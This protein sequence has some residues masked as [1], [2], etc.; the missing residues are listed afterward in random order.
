MDN[1]GFI[2]L[3]LNNHNSS[4]VIISIRIPYQLICFLYLWTR[5]SNLLDFIY[6]V[7]NMKKCS[8][9]PVEYICACV[10]VCVCASDTTKWYQSWTEKEGRAFSSRFL[11][12]GY[13]ITIAMI[14][15]HLGLIESSEDITSVGENQPRQMKGNE[16]ASE[17]QKEEGRK[18]SSSFLLMYTNWGYASLLDVH[19]AQRQ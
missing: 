8:I 11:A 15:I 4:H 1:S 12:E 16:R 7:H 5:W 18:D 2:I 13:Q 17:R 3:I 6:L 10:C 9:W 19:S 14:T